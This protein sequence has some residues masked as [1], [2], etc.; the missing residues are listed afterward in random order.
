MSSSPAAASRPHRRSASCSRR[1]A[2]ITV[3]AETVTDE[4]RQLGEDGVVM[5]LPRVFRA[6]DLDGSRLVYAATGNRR[7]DAAVSAAARVR[8]IPVNVVDAP[9][10]ST[11][12][13]PAI[14]DR[15][16]VTVAI[17]TEGAAPV[18]AREIKTKLEAWLPANF[19]MLAARAQGLRDLRRRQRSRCARPPQ[20]LG[21]AALRTFPSRRAERRGGRGRAHPRDGAPERGCAGQG[22]RAAWR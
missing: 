14:V 8:G 11:F 17:G 10:L 3:I 22:T 15:D 20:A 18:L 9:K 16:P 19:G 12:I 13:T 4:L 7:T 2:R 1:P 5:I 6:D 21:A